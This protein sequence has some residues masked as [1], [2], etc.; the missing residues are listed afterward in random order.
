MW[1]RIFVFVLWWAFL[2]SD[3]D[4]RLRKRIQPK[5]YTPKYSSIVM[6]ADT[7]QV[8]HNE[9]ANG[10]RHP[11]SLTKMMTLYMVF[12]ALK[13]GRI[14]L[15]TRMPIS[16]RA[17]RQA[18]SK[19]GLL[20]GETISIKTAILGL[21]TKSANDAAVVVA[22]FLAGSEEAFARKM[23]QKA[24]GL[25]MMKTVFRNASGLPNPSQL[26]SAK[27]M[28]ILSRALYRDYP[29]QYKYFSLKSFNHKGIEHRNHNH[30]LGKVAGVDGIK[31][32]YIGASGFNL[33]A[34][35]VRLNKNNHRR[36]LITVVMGGANRHWRD[37]RVTELLESYFARE[38]ARRPVIESVDENDLLNEL[39]YEE[40]AIETT[41]ANQPLSNKD[42]DSLLHEV[43]TEGMEPVLNE[44]V[45]PKKEESAESPFSEDTQAQSNRTLPTNWKVPSPKS[46]VKSPPSQGRTLQLSTLSCEKKAQDLAQK[47][48]KKLGFGRPNVQKIRR[49]K[50]TLYSAQITGIPA[51]KA[52]K[53]CRLLVGKC[54]VLA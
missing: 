36:R 10:I 39:I 3:A 18:P 26:T 7:G 5:P 8:L 34:S 37:R 43:S 49:G 20:P 45:A 28:A 25:G 1:H 50:Q 41:T 27:D 16:L 12:E 33:A 52:N 9:D 42:I 48:V 22:E 54:V 40:E 4:A 31:T 14:S 21:V 6:D 15:E 23:T 46:V 35:A 11:A 29:N 51:L 24:R 19:L 47:S 17:S 13:E 2:M 38:E 44:T 53:A 32:G 30:L